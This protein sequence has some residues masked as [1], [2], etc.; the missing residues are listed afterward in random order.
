MSY[1]MI[2][3][4]NIKDFEKCITKNYL[5]TNNAMPPLYGS[6]EII[7]FQQKFA[8]QTLPIITVYSFFV[9]WRQTEWHALMNKNSQGNAKTGNNLSSSFRPKSFSFFQI[10]YPLDAWTSYAV[11]EVLVLQLVMNADANIPNSS[12]NGTQHDDSQQGNI[13]AK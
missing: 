7:N 6:K 1:H 5:A 4:C 9:I 12:E 3:W 11:A 13:S 10:C 8:E 2:S